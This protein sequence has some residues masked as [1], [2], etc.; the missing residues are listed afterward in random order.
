MSVNRLNS[1]QDTKEVAEL[2]AVLE[3]TKITEQKS[4]GTCEL[5]T[6]IA[7]KYQKQI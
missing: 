2:E 3:I 6:A 5:A 7:W 1:W 4:R